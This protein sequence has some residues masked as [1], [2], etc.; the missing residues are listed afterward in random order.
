M[1]SAAAGASSIWEAH[2]LE[3]QVRDIQAAAKH[4]A[5]SPNNHVVSGRICLGLDPGT[6][7]F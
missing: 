7:R 2:P 5:M 3:R 4:I 6:Q 1:V